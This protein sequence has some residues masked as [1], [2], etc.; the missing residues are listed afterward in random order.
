MS[1]RERAVTPVISTI[2]VVAIVVILA[3]TVSVALL[4][5]TEDLTEPAPLVADTTGEF[6]PEDIET[7]GLF[8][9]H[10]LRAIALALK[11]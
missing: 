3:A 11:I 1:Q 2:L 6:I 4:G 10:T 9:S 5:I 8:G 7:T